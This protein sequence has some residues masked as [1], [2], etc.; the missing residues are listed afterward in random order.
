[1][2]IDTQITGVDDVN[3]ILQQVAPR[4]AKN[5]MRATVHGMAGEI[6]KDIRKNARKDTRNLAKSVK[7]KRRRGGPGYVQSDVLIERR[8]FY[9]RY[10]EYGT[11]KQAEEPFVMPAIEAFRGVMMKSF[12]TSFAKKFEAAMKRRAR[13]GR[14]N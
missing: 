12:L 11:M 1:M 7:S 9:W 6:R 10:F 8:A 5:I 14:R 3:R 13:R 2:R 4:E